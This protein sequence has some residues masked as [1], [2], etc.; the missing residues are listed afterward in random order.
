MKWASFERMNVYE[1]GQQKQQ[2]EQGAHKAP[3]A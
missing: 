2:A 3:I 1:A